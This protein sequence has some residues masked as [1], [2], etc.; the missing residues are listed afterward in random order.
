MKVVTKQTLRSWRLAFVEKKKK[1]EKKY[2]NRETEQK[3]CSKKDVSVSVLNVTKNCTWQKLNVWIFN[4]NA[5]RRFSNGFRSAKRIDKN[6]I[7]LS[8]EHVESWK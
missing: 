3:L 5:L 4:M 1:K 7:T 2:L 8:K 6:I